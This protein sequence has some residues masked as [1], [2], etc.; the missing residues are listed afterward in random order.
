LVKEGDHVAAGQLLAVL[1]TVDYAL[2]VRQLRVQYNQQ[3]TELERRRQMHAAKNMSDNDFEKFQSGVKQM[4]LQLALQE[5]K[6]KYCRLY[7]PSAGVI[8]K[9]NFEVSEMVDAGTPVFEL[10]DNSH[11]EVVVDLPVNEYV[12]RNAFRTFRCHTAMAP[13]QSF[14][15]QMK[16]LV[17]RADNNQL[18]QLRLT[19]PKGSTA[20][21]TPGMNVTVDINTAGAG[22]TGGEEV[23]VPLRTVFERDGKDYVWVL[24]PADST[25]TAKQVTTAGTVA[26]SKLTITSGLSGSDRIVRA[27]V[28]HLVDGEKVKVINENSETNIGNVL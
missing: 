27:G 13:E 18:Y 3:L 6:L 22:T 4:A 5:N 2:G 14:E 1:D 26:D 17:P 24:N 21:L 7:A 23:T 10:M 12:Q 11:L 25:I 20:S 28:H 8:A 9:S 16:S 15:L 19:L